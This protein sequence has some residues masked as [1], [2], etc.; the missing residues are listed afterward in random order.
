VTTYNE[1]AYVCRRGDTWEELSKHFY[2]TD[3]YAKALQRHSQI[4]IRASEQ[5]ARTGQPT[6][7]DRIFVP[8]AYVLEGL[9]PDL[10]PQPAAPPSPTM[11]P[12]TY[13]PQS[14]AQPQPNR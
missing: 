8:Q 13:A 6:E 2:K 7:G 1:V 12:A 4:H 9:Y 5:M 10:S 14:G 11:V 3:R